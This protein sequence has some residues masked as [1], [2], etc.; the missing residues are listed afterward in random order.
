MLREVSFG[1]VTDDVKIVEPVGGLEVDDR[2]VDG[3]ISAGDEASV[4]RIRSEVIGPGS[5]DPVSMTV[6]FASV[7]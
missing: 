1:S 5:P 6:L 2:V 7:W 3:T 4:R